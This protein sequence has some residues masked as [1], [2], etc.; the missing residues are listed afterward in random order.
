MAMRKALAFSLVIHLAVLL[1]A[2]FGVPVAQRE[3][4]VGS[5]P[6]AIDVVSVADTTNLPPSAAQAEKPVPAARVDTKP[7][8]DARRQAETRAAADVKPQ[9]PAP[10]KPETKK[11]QP[12]PKTDPPVQAKPQQP[13]QA[14]PRQAEKPTPQP[15]AKAEAQPAPPQPAP[16]PVPERDKAA[17]PVPPPKPVPQREKPAQQAPAAVAKNEPVSAPPEAKPSPAADFQSV[18]KSV[19][20][21]GRSDAQKPVAQAAP[22]KAET[23]AKQADGKAK[24]ADAPEQAFASL[25][26]EALGPGAA[27][28][29]TSAS[30]RTYNAAQP[31]T[32]SEIDEVRRQIERCWN[33]PPGAQDA[34]DYV[35]TIR[36]E[37]SPDATPRS[38]IVLN[39]A[40]M[41]GSAFHR[42][43]AESALRA[44]L[45]PRCHP[46]KLPVEK[47]DHWKT[48]TLVFNPKDMLG[49]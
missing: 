28:P 2:Y 47:Y 40:T 13:A 31:I 9:P 18:L 4:V 8:V 25:I 42:A 38:A 43:A 15:A 5:E 33:I 11:A 32:V 35:V 24:N 46:F 6:V 17:A 37:M 14:K 19:G 26:K 39:E 45:N 36:V 10:L 23:E 49:T 22:P 41:Q 12:P 29:P 44:V 16:P 34:G 48:M 20:T 7:K 3:L 21:L 30:G 1:L 27:T